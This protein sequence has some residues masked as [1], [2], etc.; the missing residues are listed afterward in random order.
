MVTLAL[1]GRLGQYAGGLLEGGRGEP[2]V[3]R[4]RCLGDAHQLGTAVGRFL[5]VGLELVVGVVEELD[6]HHRPGQ[7]R[8][9]A[10]VDDLHTPGHLAHD[11]LDVLV[12]DRHALVAVDVLDFLGEVLLGL[13]GPAELHHELGV[14]RSV[15][16]RGAH[17]DLLAVLDV[18]VAGDRNRLLLDLA[19]VADDRDLALTPD[20]LDSYDS[21]ELRH[22]RGSLGG[23]GLEE[24]HHAR[25]AVGDVAL[26]HTTG[27]E[28]AHG[29]LGPGLADGLGGDDADGLAQLHELVGRE[30][31]AVTGGTD[32]LDRV[33][34][35]CGAHA[36]ARHCRVVA[37]ALDVVDH[38]H[39]SRFDGR[40]VRQRDGL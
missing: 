11:Q 28:G 27:V 14:Q 22:L 35:Q 19:I 36:N 25:Q 37:Q 34:G 31:Q 6:V 3:G 26:G 5:A 15:V 39:G 30:R 10:V 7:P 40:P 33:T 20:Q 12:V 17:L 4:Q 21:R 8:R 29:Q 24:L 2:R 38:Q 23:A 16:Q 9:I 18:Q 32:S 1:D 13:A